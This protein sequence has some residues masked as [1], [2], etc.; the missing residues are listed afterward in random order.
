MNIQAE[1]SLP[2]EFKFEE[3]WYRHIDMDAE[4]EDGWLI[5]SNLNKC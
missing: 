1:A 5:R 4:K 2:N 3:I